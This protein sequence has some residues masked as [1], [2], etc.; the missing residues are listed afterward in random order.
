MENLPIEEWQK[1][2][3][4]GESAAVKQAISDLN[5]AKVHRS[6]AGALAE[7]AH[8]LNLPQ[9]VLRLLNPIVR[10][11]KASLDP[12]TP[13]ELAEYAMALNR[14]GVVDEASSILESL[15]SADYSKLWL[16]NAFVNMTQWNY[17]KAATCLRKHLRLQEKG[18]YAAVIAKVNL[19]AT[20]V[21][22]ERADEAEALLKEIVAF[23]EQN[24]M[25]VLYGNSHELLGQVYLLKGEFAEAA[26][27][28]EVAEKALQGSHGLG[29]FFV[30]KWQT[31][32]QARQAKSQG[33]GLSILLELE[34]RAREISHWETIRDCEYA[35]ALITEEKSRANRLYFGT[36]FKEY[37]SRLKRHFGVSPTWRHHYMWEADSSSSAVVLNVAEGKTSNSS[38]ELNPGSVLHQL[39]FVMTRDFYRPMPLGLIFS[40]LYPGEYFDPLTSFDRAFKS[41]Q[42]LRAEFQ[43]SGL[44]LEIIESGGSYK[45]QHH[46]LAVRVD[47]KEKLPAKEWLELK[48]LKQKLPDRP[49]KLKEVM[50]V[51]GLSESKVRAILNHPDNKSKVQKLGQGPGTRYKLAS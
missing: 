32:L 43:G 45:F 10:N 48:Q 23:T 46:G 12:A 42:R 40:R 30:E 50:D 15:A 33:E 8:R 1:R 5:L 51:S 24:K 38:L 22:M 49:V 16:Y 36:P 7:L 29:S 9:M 31:I 44:G 11:E 4:A 21:F 34:Q 41:I 26:S 17:T 27:A 25:K 37:R 14:V 28:L 19:A 20:Y 35:E 2:M 39:L 18:S 13:L 6:Q 3:Q 47:L